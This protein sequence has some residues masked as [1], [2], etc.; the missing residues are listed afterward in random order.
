MVRIDREQWRAEAFDDV[1]VP[2]GSTV[3]VTEV[4]GTRVIVAADS[5]PGLEP[6]AS[7][8]TGGDSR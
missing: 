2:A 6:P 4:R 1:A 5:P 8:P 3:I 7:P